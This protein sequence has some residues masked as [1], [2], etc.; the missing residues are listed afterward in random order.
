VLCIVSTKKQAQQVFAALPEKDGAFHLSTNMYPAHRTRVLKDIRQ[1]LNDKQPCRVVS[2]S[3]VEAGVDLDFPVVYR[4][5]AG[6]DS[7]AQ[8][9]GRCNREGSLEY[10]Q[11]YVFESEELPAMPWLRR[12]VSRAQEIL[13]LFPEEDCLGL[14]P[15]RRYFELL[16]DGENLDKKEIVKRLKLK[17]G[18]ELILPFREIA[19]DFRLIE[20]DGIGLLVS[21]R[22]ED[23]KEVERLIRELRN[24]EFP[25][26][27][28]R[29]LQQYSVAVRSK[30]LEKLICD[31]AVEMIREQYPV[32]VNT[33]A[34]EDNL[35]LLV[36][37]AEIWD[38]EA[39]TQ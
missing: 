10:G 21:G 2:T 19:E 33:A 8:A 5:M 9:A 30:T 25:F 17:M 1:C 6:L 28:S 35:G 14:A 12:R 11:V 39:L 24:T 7:I 23:E 22:K 15:M 31:G 13:R 34:Y 26:S 29:K 16:Y 20:D 36:E 38:P 3:L 18:T 4:A 32:L 27:T 37:M